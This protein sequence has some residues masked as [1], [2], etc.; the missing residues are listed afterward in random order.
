MKR[1][2]S[3]YTHFIEGKHIYLREVRLS[4][5]NDEY[6]NWLNDHE[7]SRFLETRFFPQSITSITKYVES[8]VDSRESVFLAV[9]EK[10]TNKHIG[11]AKI[12]PIN[13][14]HRAANF[15]LILG[16][17]SI[18]GKG[19]GTQA[20]KLLVDYAAYTLNLNRL[21]ETAYSNHARTIKMCLN[22]GFKI[23]GVMKKSR[24]FRGEYVDEVVLGL[25]LQEVRGCK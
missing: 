8:L 6:Y 24:F 9:I 19:Y 1:K 16:D 17:K 25:N 20:I 3:E 23:E 22:A 18:W 11:N 13:W 2:N 21:N 15:A 14:I 12:G 7:I 10:K 5:V 4:D